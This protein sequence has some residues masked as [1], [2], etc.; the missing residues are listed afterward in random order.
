M[1]ERRSNLL[2]EVIRSYVREAEPVGSR[3]LEGALGVSSATIRHE[4][5]QLEEEG[6]LAQPYTSA[7]R[8][9]TLKGYQYFVEHL[10]QAREPAAAEQH[11]LEAAARARGEHEAAGK[12]VAK[13]LADHSRTAAVIGFGPYDVFYTGLANLFTQPEFHQARMVVHM[14]KVIDHLDEAVARLFHSSSE[15]P[16]EVLLGRQNP[17]GE[18]CAMVFTKLG[19]IGRAQLV[20]ILGPLRMDYDANVGRLQYVRS[21]FT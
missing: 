17:F 18:D 5:A 6:Y 11:A 9:P 3:A 20:G 15:T 12:A 13:C 21:L 4:M 7:G 19:R 16:V 10:M 14:G 2:A 1:E 8:L